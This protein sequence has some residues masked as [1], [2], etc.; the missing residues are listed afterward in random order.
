MG[1]DEWSEYIHG[2]LML[3]LSKSLCVV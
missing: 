2:E 3:I 1:K